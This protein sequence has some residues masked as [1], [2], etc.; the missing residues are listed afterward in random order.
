M[1]TEHRGFVLCDRCGKHRD[2][3]ATT[4]CVYRLDIYE[5]E[6]L[7]D[8]ENRELRA[9]LAALTE[10]SYLSN[11]QFMALVHNRL[12]DEYGVRRYGGGTSPCLSKHIAVR[13]AK[14]FQVA[15]ER[16]VWVVKRYVSDWER[17]E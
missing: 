15:G 14:E 16:N 1:A 8:A 2:D 6:R 5:R 3:W 10:G 13:K 9:E 7:L 4:E 12:R 17:A 11:A